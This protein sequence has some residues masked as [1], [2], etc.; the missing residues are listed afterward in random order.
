M[1][2]QV[3]GD[4]LVEAVGQFEQASGGRNPERLSPELAAVFELNRRGD[5][6]P[7]TD[8]RG[9]D[10]ASLVGE[11]GHNDFNYLTQP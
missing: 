7:Q 5:R 1:Q 10:F 2:S 3:D 6:V 8:A 4:S 11:V 9:S